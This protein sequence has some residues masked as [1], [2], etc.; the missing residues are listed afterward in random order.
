MKV[1]DKLL[2]DMPNMGCL[3]GTAYQMLLSQLNEAL[4]EAAIPVTTA[5]YM[6][7]RALYTKE[8]LQQCDL[9]E[10]VGK[11]QSAVCRTV[12]TMEK[13]DLVRTEIISHK[14]RRVYLSEAGKDL[15]PEIL[16]VAQERQEA[17]SYL[18]TDEE[19]AAFEKTLRKIINNK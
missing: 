4:L 7:L 12:S 11:D 17:I 5:E 9:A 6:I 1:E 10:M 3:V 8:G 15:E 13:K 18:F 19:L 2:Y 14:C 16:R